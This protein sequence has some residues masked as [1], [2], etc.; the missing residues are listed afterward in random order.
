[1]KR[2]SNTWRRARALL[3]AL[4]AL[5]ACAG[6][7][8]AGPTPQPT[9][10]SADVISTLGP[11]DSTVAPAEPG[12]V[13]VGFAAQEFERA[14][15]EPLIAAFNQQNPDVHVEF[16]PLGMQSSQSIDQLIRQIVSSADTAA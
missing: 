1:M 3:V 16:V 9:D 12:V 6:P 5:S 2:L 10:S 13:T 4:L 15:Y 14:A 11:A 8:A 7:D